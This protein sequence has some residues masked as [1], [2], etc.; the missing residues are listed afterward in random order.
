[1][2]VMVLD[3]RVEGDWEYRRFNDGTEQWSYKDHTRFFIERVKDK[4]RKRWTVVDRGS[5]TE[6]SA[7]MYP[8]KALK[9]SF[10]EADAAKVALVFIL[11]GN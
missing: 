2:G 10:A 1:M 9:T 8:P 7:Q 6:Y 3:S 11:S 4:R 5:D